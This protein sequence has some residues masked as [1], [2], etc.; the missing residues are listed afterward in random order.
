MQVYVSNLAEYWKGVYETLLWYTE[1]VPHIV[2]AN[3]LR[4]GA[5]RKRAQRVEGMLAKAFACSPEDVEGRLDQLMK[6]PNLQGEQRQ[7]PLGIGFV[8]AVAGLLRYHCPNYTFL[9][10]APVGTAVFKDV[11]HPPRRAIDIVALKGG[12]ERAIISVKWSIRHDRLRDLLDECTV[13]KKHRPKLKFYVVTNEFMPAR[14]RK[15][16]EDPCVDEVFH[17]NREMVLEVNNGNSRLV[18]LKDF[19]DIIVEFR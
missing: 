19:G 7:N 12:K 8:C 17:V 16:I 3:S 13:Y 15:L 6:Q 14:L 1:E 5:W 18:G 11:K 10:E 9:D 4:E 2:E